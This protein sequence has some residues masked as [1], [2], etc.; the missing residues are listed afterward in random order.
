MTSPIS[1]PF[2]VFESAGAFFASASGLASGTP[3]LILSSGAYLCSGIYSGDVLDVIGGVKI[4]VVDLDV[5][6][7][8]VVGTGSG[9][10]TV[11]VSSWTIVADDT[12]PIVA[13][14]FPGIPTGDRAQRCAVHLESIT[15]DS[16]AFTAGRPD[17]D[18]AVELRCI[19]E[20]GGAN[21]H[22]GVGQYWI[23]ANIG[24]YNFLKTAATTWSLDAL[25]NGAA[26]F[27][28]HEVYPDST[29]HRCASLTK[30][31]SASDD[32]SADYECDLTNSGIVT[33]TDGWR[34]ELEAHQGASGSTITLVVTHIEWGAGG[35]P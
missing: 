22:S 35:H 4:P 2:A 27:F 6:T 15:L 32:A 26:F 29:H 20:S 8:Y 28:Q 34:W 16:P 7:C 25:S 33:G 10:L 21:L 5:T 3:V 1:S 31:A 13:I 30:A 9:G 18:T 23:G 12:N 17:L 19:G 24:K 14:Q 11:G